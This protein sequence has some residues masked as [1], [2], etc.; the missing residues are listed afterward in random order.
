MRQLIHLSRHFSVVRR[1][2]D[3]GICSNVDDND[4]DNEQNELEQ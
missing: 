1:F 3:I 4:N 2:V